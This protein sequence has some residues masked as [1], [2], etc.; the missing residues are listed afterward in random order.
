MAAHVLQHMQH[1]GPEAALG[2]QHGGRLHRG[3]IR[4]Q[5]Q[6]AGPRH[7]VAIEEGERAAMQGDLRD[8]LKRPAE[9]GSSQREGRR[10]RQ[11]HHFLSRHI[12]PERRTNA[13]MHGVTGGEHRDRRATKLQDLR[14]RLAETCTPGE[15][16]FQPGQAGAIDHSIQPLSDDERLRLPDDG[17]RFGSQAFQTV[18][19]DADDG[20]PGDIRVLRH[21]CRALLP[22]HLPLPRPWQSRRDDHGPRYRECP[23]NLRSVLP[24]FRRHLR[25]RPENRG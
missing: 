11:H 18:V 17:L 25:S 23:L 21:W 16:P 5:R 22:R 24:C 3:G 15:D 1:R 8:R 10:A 20:E 19:A 9:T 6:N 4:G 2:E 13:E 12:A 14:Q 7:D